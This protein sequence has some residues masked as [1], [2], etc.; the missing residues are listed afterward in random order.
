MV[1]ELIYHSSQSKK[2]LY[3]ESIE[4][5]SSLEKA[6]TNSEIN[7]EQSLGLLTWLFGPNS[8]QQ[9]SFKWHA[10]IFWALVL[11]L[12]KKGASTYLKSLFGIW[13][14]LPVEK[15]F[16][17]DEEQI[18]DEL[19]LNWKDNIRIFVINQ[20]FMVVKYGNEITE[21]SIWRVL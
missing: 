14:E 3:K 18:D 21:K 2:N 19:D 15:Y 1:W 9:L 5:L 13:W 4:C 8:N 10:T 17:I 6:I 16:T 12:S 7:D 20:I 11:K